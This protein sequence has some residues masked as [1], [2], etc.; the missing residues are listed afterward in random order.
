MNTQVSSRSQLIHMKCFATQN[1]L[2]Y[3]DIVT[4]CSTWLLDTVKYYQYQCLLLLDWRDMS[5]NCRYY[6]HMP[7]GGRLACLL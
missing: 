5:V 7:F 1:C 3:N 6:V 4:I 2:I